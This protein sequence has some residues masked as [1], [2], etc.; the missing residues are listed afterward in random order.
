[1]LFDGNGHRCGAR[2]LEVVGDVEGV[3]RE[4]VLQ[5]EGVLGGSPC[6]LDGL[7]IGRRWG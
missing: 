3:L 5:G 2:P 7:L 4:G 1:M 6:L